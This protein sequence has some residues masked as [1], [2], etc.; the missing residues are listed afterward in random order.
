[1]N[2][3]A[4]IVKSKR[5]C[6]GFALVSF[7]REAVRVIRVA[8]TAPVT[9]ASTSRRSATVSKS[10]AAS[11]PGQRHRILAIQP[12]AL[13]IIRNV[14]NAKRDLHDTGHRQKAAEH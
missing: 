1:L 10:T 8:L 12:L 3:N 5:L 14:D 6:I 7:T 4:A 2:L 11:I 9:L 13:E